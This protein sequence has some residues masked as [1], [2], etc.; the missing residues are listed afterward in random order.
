MT[1]RLVVDSYDIDAFL[2]CPKCLL[3]N[4]VHIDQVEMVGPQGQFARLDGPREDSIN[5]IG[6]QTGV[7]QSVE[8]YTRRQAVVLIGWCENGCNFE[9]GFIQHKGDTYVEVREKPDTPD[10]LGEHS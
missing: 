3:T 5:P 7:H 9:I 10:P 1:L 4:G 6:L 8:W 2:R